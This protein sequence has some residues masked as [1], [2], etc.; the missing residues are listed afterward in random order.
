MG[1]LKRLFGGGKQKSKKYVDKQG[2]Y[3][4]VQCDNCQSVV[5][6]RADKQH[7]LQ[8]EGN[9]L[10]WHKTIVDSRCFRR[11]QTVVHLNSNYEV[12][13]SELIGGHY[14]SEEEYNQIL[15]EQ[16]AAKEAAANESS[17]VGETT[18]NDG[19]AG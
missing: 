14:I 16:K 13:N 8:R 9:G 18:E 10:T 11:M 17:S 6:V 12:T 1:F 7:D 5:R 4:H 19:E 3:F 15:A 2:I